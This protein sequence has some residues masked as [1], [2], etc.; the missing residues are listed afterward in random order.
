MKIYRCQ[1]CKYM[2]S[3]QPGDR[4]NGVAARVKMGRHYDTTHKILLPPD[5]DGYRWFYFLLTGKS[6]GSCVICHQPTQFNRNS[7]KYTRFCDNP[8]C[9]QVYKK[10][11]DQRMMSS[12]G[13]LTLLNDPDHQ[14][15][16]QMA[17][18]IA[19]IYNWSD[20]KTKIPYLSSFE[21]DF[22]RMLDIELNWPASDIIAPSPHTYYYEYAGKQHFYMP[23]AFIPSM[24][25]EVEIKDDGSA[26]RSQESREKDVIKDQLMRSLSAHINYIRIVNK[27]YSEF[28]KL[29]GGQKNGPV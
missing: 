5:M 17:R 23:D 2:V 25:L 24:N 16:M 14:K 18:R 29:I 4:S 21:R 19:G 1:H 22:F 10:Q 20:N 28:N 15:K 7:M 11:V 26:R 3:V 6:E 12:H 13:K 27:D 8:A 9:K